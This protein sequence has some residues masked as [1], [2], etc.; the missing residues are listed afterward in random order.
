MNQREFH[1]SV[2]THSFVEM[3]FVLLLMTSVT[4]FSSCLIGCN[5]F[6]WNIL[7]E[8]C[9]DITIA[10]HCGLW[11]GLKYAYEAD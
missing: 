10:L 11:S 1:I 7:N 6:S 5:G 3:Y 8:T 9:D 2:L 4:V